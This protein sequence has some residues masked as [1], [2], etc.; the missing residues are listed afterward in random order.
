GTAH[1]DNAA[2]ALWGG[3]I[4]S[5]CAASHPPDVQALPVPRGLFYVVLHTDIDVNTRQARAAL[6][7]SIP[8]KTA[9]RQWANTAAVVQAI[10]QEDWALL[11]RAMTDWVAEPVRARYIPHYE[12]CRQAALD[13]GALTFN[14]SGSGPSVFAFCEQR[15]I[16]DK[17]ARAWEQ[18]CRERGLG[19]HIW[20]DVIRNTGAEILEIED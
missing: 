2:P 9:V 18:I 12:A 11:A 6:P 15:A 4:L 17:V 10:Y 5:R 20:S 3:L 19:F 8:L 16:A 14:I 13:N 1:A 7:E